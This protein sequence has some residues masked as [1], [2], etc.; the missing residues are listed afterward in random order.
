MNAPF[1]TKPELPPGLA[2]SMAEQYLAR[3]WYLCLIPYGLKRPITEKWNE[4]ERAISAPGQLPEIVENVGLL[5]VQSAT[6]SID[7]DNYESAK[8]WFAERGVNLDELLSAPDAVQ[9]VSGRPGSA[10]LIYRMPTPMRSIKRSKDGKAILEFRCATAEGKT[11]QD[12][13]PPSVHPSGSIYQWAG[14][15]VTDGTPGTLPAIPEALLMIWR[16]Q[17]ESDRLP[18]G[19]V[20]GTYPASLDEVTS[21]IKVIPATDREVWMRVGMAMRLAFGDDAF[22]AWDEWCQT[23]PT[24]YTAST[25]AAQWCSFKDNH[26]EPVTLGT[27]FH[28]AYGHGWKRP[29]PD[30]SILFGNL[31]ITPEGVVVQRRLMT[32]DEV[33]ADLTP[34]SPEMP[35]ELLPPALANY[36]AEVAQTVGADP[37]VSA[38]AGMGAICAA[39]D[40]RSTLEA[41]P[42]F[43]APPVLHLITVGDPADK[44]TPASKPM[45]GILKDIEHEDIEQHKV[46]KHHWEGLEA[47]HASAKKAYLDTCGAPE[48]NMDG[49]IMAPEVPDL[50]PMPASKRLVLNDVT[51]AKILNIAEHRPYGML[52]YTEELSGLAAKLTNPGSGE[53]R[54]VFTIGFDTGSYFQSRVST[55]DKFIENLALALYGN[56]QPKVLSKYAP[57]LE[58]D[59]LLQ[60][61]IIGI[62]HREL[63]RPGREMPAWMSCRDD[64]EQMVRHAHAVGERHYKTDAE[65][66]AL[67]H[68]WDDHVIEL[69][70]RL[71]AQGYDTNVTGAVGKLVGIAIRVCCVF[72]MATAPEATV[73]PAETV[74]NAIKFII[75]F[76]LPGIYATAQ[77]A[78]REP[79]EKWV[80]GHVLDYAHEGER[81]LAKIVDSARRLR[82]DTDSAQFKERVRTAMNALSSIEGIPWI[83]LTHDLGRSTIWAINPNLAT[84]FSKEREQRIADR[85]RLVDN[86]STSKQAL[87]DWL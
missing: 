62:L 8:A 36:A 73:V 58:T 26:A 34:T 37:I 20:E 30:V 32:P 14:A 11:V 80:V 33:V 53:D 57:L 82:G 35:M 42:G 52:Y 67:F 29:L 40:A 25:Q 69:N 74:R 13:L 77:L 46:A 54:T 59:G 7:I 18:R 56:I 12:V 65:G 44:K 45:F 85:A 1:N 61:A 9:I 47:Q 22:A 10:K 27:L 81:S 48:F 31:D 28:M 49:N 78:G 19:D 72:H 87:D 76:A 6:C 41:W 23:S 2:R 21:A 43:S 63:T 39:V 71:A 75:R 84:V 3:H 16:N 55:G 83:K 86:I 60:R 38:L 4:P 66:A 70:K 50:P 68:R 24:G 15:G 17:I 79:L 51:T 5:H 64:Y